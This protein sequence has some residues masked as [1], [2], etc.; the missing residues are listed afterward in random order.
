MRG[1]SLGALIGVG[2]IG[3]A[4]L[5][6]KAP[7]PSA[8]AASALAAFRA[9]SPATTPAFRPAVSSCDCASHNVCTGPHG[10]RYC[11]TS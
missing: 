2:L 8:G 3:G 11:L 6:L 4:V 10:G 5:L 7:T 1:K 9:L